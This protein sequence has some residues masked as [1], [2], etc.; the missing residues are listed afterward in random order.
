MISFHGPIGRRC[1]LNEDAI[2]GS[3]ASSSRDGMGG[4]KAGDMASQLSVEAN[5][6]GGWLGD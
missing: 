2:I 1:S 4:R 3:I 6:T 5:A